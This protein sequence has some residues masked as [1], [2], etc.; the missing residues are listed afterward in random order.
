MGLSPLG[1]LSVGVSSDDG[2]AGFSFFISFSSSKEEED[3]EGRLPSG[4]SFGCNCGGN[5]GSTVDSTGGVT[6]VTFFPHLFFA[7]FRPL[8]LCFSIN[9]RRSCLTSSRRVFI[10]LPSSFS[11]NFEE[12][13]SHNLRKFLSE[14]MAIF[15]S[16][17][18][19]FSSGPFAH[20]MKSKRV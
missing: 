2:S 7:L 8:L 12:T 4:L 1:G 11:T 6:V 13:V 3:E 9:A 19:S 16:F 18:G 15:A 10:K 17:F 14:V 5:F 20:C